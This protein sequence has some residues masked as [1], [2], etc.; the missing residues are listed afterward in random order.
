MTNVWYV[1]VVFYLFVRLFSCVPCLYILFTAVMRWIKDV[2]ILRPDTKLQHKKN[3][4]DTI[5]PVQDVFIIRYSKSQKNH[6]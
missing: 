3:I 5:F 2:P 6:D 1:Y 4:V